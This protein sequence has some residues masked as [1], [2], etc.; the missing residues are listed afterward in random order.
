MIW[1]HRLTCEVCAYVLDDDSDSNLHALRTHAN[2][3]HKAL[4]SSGCEECRSI[5]ADVNED[6]LAFQKVS[7]A[8][9]QKMKE[10][11]KAL[12]TLTKVTI[13]DH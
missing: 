10:H 3:L 2:I 13:S 8:T 1:S 6:E 12:H 5:S 11:I 7:F 4:Q 9:L